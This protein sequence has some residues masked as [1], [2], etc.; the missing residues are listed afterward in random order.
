MVSL[1]FMECELQLSCNQSSWI[2]QM[3]AKQV[4]GGSSFPSFSRVA[5]CKVSHD[6]SRQMMA[7]SG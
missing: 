1:D 5:G 7:L 2:H 3:S 4:G 6:I